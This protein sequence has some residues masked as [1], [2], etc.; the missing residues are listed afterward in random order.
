MQILTWLDKAK[1]YSKIHEHWASP[2][3]FN[4]AFIFMFNVG[5][6]HAHMENTIPQITHTVLLS[7]LQNLLS[8][9]IN[10]TKAKA[11][12]GKKKEKKK[13]KKK[14]GK[15]K[16]TF[17]KHIEQFPLCQWGFLFKMKFLSKIA[18]SIQMT[19]RWRGSKRGRGRESKSMT[20]F[21]GS[22]NEVFSPQL[23]NISESNVIKWK[24]TW[25][26]KN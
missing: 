23:E 17:L 14:K 5:N 15:N 21:S 11:L 2:A 6:M 4:K 24:F 16:Y 13:K 26:I 18:T 22:E 25:K 9:L 7:V 20:L 8:F 12:G 1:K 19:F 10:V 3:W